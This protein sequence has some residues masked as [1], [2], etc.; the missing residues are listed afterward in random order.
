MNAEVAFLSVN[1]FFPGIQTKKECEE[2]IYKEPIFEE[3]LQMVRYGFRKWYDFDCS[4]VLLNH[5]YQRSFNSYAY[6]DK[7]NPV[8]IHI[9]QLLESVLFAFNAAHEIAHVY[10]MSKEAQY[11]N[12]HK[13]QAEYSAD[14]IAYD[15]LLRLIIDKYGNNLIFEEYVYLAP[16]MRMDF[17]DIY[18]NVDNILYGK[19]YNSQ[20]RP[21]PKQRK[22]ALF[23]VVDREVYQL[24]IEDGNAVYDSFCMVYDDFLDKLETYRK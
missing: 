20:T 14:E 5:N 24:N 6:I 16:M 1:K 10:Q 19:I 2:Q 4:E 17:F 7:E 13:K 3:M 11:W 8:F 9:D 12:E 22:E 18:Y 15:I 23:S 21:T